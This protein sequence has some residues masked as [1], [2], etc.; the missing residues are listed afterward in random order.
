M[1]LTQPAV[2][3]GLLRSPSVSFG[4]LRQIFNK[5]PII[6]CEEMPELIS[7]T[8][9]EEEQI[10]DTIVQKTRLITS[11]NIVP[12]YI[13]SAMGLAATTMVLESSEEILNESL[14][15]IVENQDAVDLAVLQ[16][17]ETFKQLPDGTTQA[18]AETW[19]ATP[20]L[21]YFIAK[22]K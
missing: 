9:V 19:L 4:L 13:G 18:T 5:F 2:Y 11:A 15:F 3:Y 21:N 6:P 8:L 16:V 17:Y 12:A 22:G 14:T 1:T 20:G 7:I 10:S